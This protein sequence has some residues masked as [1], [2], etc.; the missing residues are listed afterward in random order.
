MEIILGS[1]SPRR[2]EIM[3]SL[4]LSFKIVSAD[5]DES[6]KESDPEK[7]VIELSRR[8]ADAV[9]KK[10]KGDTLIIAADTV[11]YLDNEYY[12]KPKDKEDAVRILSSLCGKTHKVY[13]GVTLKGKDGLESFCE[14]SKV[15]MKKLTQ[16]EI[17][18]YIEKYLPLDKAGAYGIQDK[19]VV[20]DYEGSYSNIVGLPIE[21]L[22]IRL[23]NWS[24]L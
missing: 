13:T 18:A 2:K 15:R 14:I 6:T 22:K 3:E 23:K 10:I 11:V 12:N 5:V 24:I 19:S 4:N 17:R 16:S 1:S 21:K 9:A 8:K 20:E 7:R